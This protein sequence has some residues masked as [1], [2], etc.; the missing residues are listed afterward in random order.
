MF[1]LVI[2]DLN[3]EREYN[4]EYS[5]DK[6][7]KIVDQIKEEHKEIG[8]LMGYVEFPNA[9]RKYM[10][11]VFMKRLVHKSRDLFVKNCLIFTDTKMIEK[12]RIKIVSDESGEET[13]KALN[14]FIDDFKKYDEQWFK[15]HKIEYISE[16]GIKLAMEMRDINSLFYEL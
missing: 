12:L 2:K 9:L 6:L 14:E 16:N 4:E 15:T 3:I 10:V 5:I 8:D 13:E 1:T 7:F 11:V